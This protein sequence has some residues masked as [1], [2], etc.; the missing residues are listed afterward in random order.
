LEETFLLKIE[1]VSCESE[2]GDSLKNISFSVKKGESIAIF[3]PEDSGIEIICPL[4][5]GLISEYTGNVYYKGL[6]VKSF[7]YLETHKYRKELGYLQRDYGLISNMSVHENIS[8]P[9][10]YHSKLSSKEIEVIVNWMIENFGML[11]CKDKRPVGL[12]RSEKLRTAFL[13]A[14]VLDPELILLEHSLEGQCLF[15][16]RIFLASIKQDLI[17][18]TISAIFTGYDPRLYMDLA[19]EYIML[20]KGNIVFNGTREEFESMD[21]P[22]LRQ[23]FNSLID[24]P[25]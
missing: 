13:R 20:H 4:V 21:N 14:I 25:V 18:R 10:K 2:K 22:Y 19:S 5:A 17:S 3:G 9:L 16:S 11:H 6:S 23:Y 1:N 12:S 7:D 8:L 15:S 24:S